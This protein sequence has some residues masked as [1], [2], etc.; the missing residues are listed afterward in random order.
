MNTR[1]PGRRSGEVDPRSVSLALSSG[2]LA[3]AQNDV[4]RR[5]G[6]RRMTELPKSK[7][8]DEAPFPVATKTLPCVSMAGPGGAQ[9]APRAVGTR[10]DCSAPRGPLA[11][12]E[13]TR[14]W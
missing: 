11:G 7:E 10:N 4:L 5:V 9:I 8:L 1:P 12:A 6:E 13:T 2:A 3:G 14:P